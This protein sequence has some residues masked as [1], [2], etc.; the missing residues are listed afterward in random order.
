MS[1]L[2]KELKQDLDKLVTLRDEIRVRLHLCNQEAKER[3]A[4]LETELDRVHDNATR[5]TKHSL[6]ELGRALKEFKNHS[7]A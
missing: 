5:V 7:Q 6:A 1:E 4:T 3:W 2:T